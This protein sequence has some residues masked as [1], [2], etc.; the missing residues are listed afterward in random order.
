MFGVKNLQQLNKAL[1]SLKL[2]LCT[3]LGVVL[4]IEPIEARKQVKS[5]TVR[6]SIPD[7]NQISASL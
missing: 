6:K 4:S 1:C 3:E 7:Y 2:E 5:F